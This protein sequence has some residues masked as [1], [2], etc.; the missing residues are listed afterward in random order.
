MK[1]VQIIKQWYKADGKLFYQQIW[2]LITEH[3]FFARFT[4]P[5]FPN[6]LNDGFCV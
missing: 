1:D 2:D 3:N 4:Y 5:I 6:S